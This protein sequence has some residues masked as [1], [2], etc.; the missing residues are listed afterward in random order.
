MVDDDPGIRMICREVLEAAGFVVRDGRRR[1]QALVE[2]ARFRPD[3]MLLDVMM[4]DWTASRPRSGFRAER[5]TALTPII[6]VSARGQ[7]T[8]KVRAFKLGADDYMVKPFDSAELRGPRRE[9]A[10]AQERELGAS[11]T[12]G[13]PGRRPSRTRSPAAAWPAAATSPSA[14]STSTT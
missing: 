13:C 1:D 8:D 6:F 7:T 10:R 5:A 14:T 11:P 2:A 4:P 3:L 9:G 12:T